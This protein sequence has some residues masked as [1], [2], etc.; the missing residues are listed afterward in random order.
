MDR[1]CV[2]YV[3]PTGTGKSHRAW[4]EAGPDAFSKCPRT[5]WWTSYQGQE[6]VVIDEF[7]GVVDISHLLRWFDRYPV[8]VETKG[9][10]VPLCAVKF[11]ITSNL[12]PDSWYPELDTNTKLALMRRL[13]IVEMDEVYVA[14]TNPTQGL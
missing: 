14:P 9:S 10:S 5:K 6:H 8:H 1:S 4:E 3:G 2:V 7:R 13:S 12:H 11:W